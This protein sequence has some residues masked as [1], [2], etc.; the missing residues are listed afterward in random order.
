MKNLIIFFL[1]TLFSLTMQAQS[2]NYQTIVRNGSGSPQVSTA[3]NLRFTVLETATS[4]VLYRETQNPTTDQYGWLSLTIGNGIPVTG[5]FATVDFSVKRYLLVECSTDGGSNFAEIGVSELSPNGTGP[6]GDTGAIGPKGDKGDAG[7]AGPK[8]DKGD[9]G[10]M[11]LQGDKGDA[12][13]MGLQGIKGD[14]GATGAIGPIGLTGPKG[15]Q[16]IQGIAGPKGDKGDDAIAQNPTIIKISSSTPIPINTELEVI[17]LTFGTI[18]FL[19]GDFNYTVSNGQLIIPEGGYYEINSN[20]SLLTSTS[21]FANTII[22]FEVVVNGST[23]NQNTKQLSFDQQSYFNE[24]SFQNKLRFETGDIVKFQIKASFIPLDFRL[25]QGDISVLKLVNLAGSGGGSSDDNQTLTVTDN[26]LSILRG[27]SVNIDASPTNEIQTISLSGDQLSLS[28]GGGSVTLPAGATGATGPQGPV[29]PI[30]PTGPTGPAGPTGA[31]GTTGAIGATGPAGVT[32]PAGPIGPAGATG[33]TGPAGPAGATGATGPIG[34]AGP[35]GPAGPDNQ[36][37]SLTGNQLSISNGNTVTLPSTGGGSLNGSGTIGSLTRWINGTTLGD[38]AFMQ[39]LESNIGLGT[40]PQTAYKMKINSTAG[41]AFPLNLSANNVPGSALHF[42]LNDATQKAEIQLQSAVTNFRTT[43]NK[44]AFNARS[45]SALPL[46]ADHLAIKSNGQVTMGLFDPYTSG[47]RLSV[48]GNVG[49]KDASLNFYDDSNVGAADISCLAPDNKLH[50]HSNKNNAGIEIISTG[51][52]IE[53][54]TN[55]IGGATSEL[56][57]ENGK[58]IIGNSSAISPKLEVLGQ[59]KINGGSPGAG[60]VLTSDAA[61]LASWQL[62][63]STGTGLWNNNLWAPT[64]SHN[65]PSIKQVLISPLPESVAVLDNTVLT[66]AAQ[67][68]NSVANFITQNT[69]TNSKMVKIH[70]QGTAS[71]FTNPLALDI[72]NRPYLDSGNGIKI[73][74][75]G[76]GLDVMGDLGAIRAKSLNI[77]IAGVFEGGGAISALGRHT[78]VSATADLSSNTSVGVR[79]NYSGTGNFNGIGIEAISLPTNAQ[80]RESQGFGI[81]G[82]FVGGNKGISVESLTNP[83]STYLL[84]LQIYSKIYGAESRPM[85]GL[86]KSHSSVGIMAVSSD[87]HA[88]NGGESYGIGVVGRSNATGTSATTIGVYGEGEGNGSRIGVMGHSAATTA[89][90]AI[91]IKGTADGSTG[92]AGDFRAAEGIHIEGT[93]LGIHSIAPTNEFVGSSTTQPIVK[94]QHFSANGG[95]ALEIQNG[96]IKVDQ[97][98]N[99]KTAF[100][101]VTASSNITGNATILNF[102]NQKASD[103]IMINR[104]LPYINRIISFYTWFDAVVGKWKIAIDDNTTMPA[105][106]NFSVI[107]IKT[108]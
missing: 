9:A 89:G 52:K 4:G 54:A 12:G 104:G 14:V 35:A 31:T 17:P 75:G 33:A 77:S 107:V 36:T 95:T 30:G 60:K 23:Q 66:V 53:M 20:L 47:D 105:G 51:G 63:T 56:V 65:T 108:E 10:I 1:L 22:I 2:F 21:Q 27:N 70:N 91:G 82:K 46:M 68:E 26:T 98:S 78:G 5:T 59:L 38:A 84:D 69:A 50:I 97:G 64:L 86:F 37:L 42:S 24:Y 67:T 3:V 72:L 55:G 45:A 88:V 102:P 19:E 6:K 34:P 99:T 40:I 74:V 28:N 106:W 80:I 103:I 44:L 76:T 93:N 11:G 71:G 7:V 92:V 85:A 90:I 43:S 87:L 101:H 39:D 32:G 96:Y 94:L 79:A 48:N 29:G 16:G 81:G 49:L 73:D 57:V 8:G 61:G 58:V 100:K 62:P 41:S 13:A 18:D 15:D 83:S 25:S